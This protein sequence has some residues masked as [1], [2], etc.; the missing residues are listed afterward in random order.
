MNCTF[1]DNAAFYGAGLTVG[2][3]G[4]ATTTNCIFWGNSTD[5]IALD[6]LN[7]AGGTL[8]VNYCDIQGGEN[9]VNVIDPS[10]STFNWGIE[11]ID[12]D[13]IFENSGNGNYHL[14]NSSPCIGAAID[15]IMI[16]GTMCHCPLIDIEGLPR[17]YPV[18]T[19][20]DMGA[21]EYQFPV[22]VE[23]NETAQPTEFS[24]SQNYPNPF[25]PITTIQYQIP[26]RSN[27]SLKVYDIIGNEIAEL[28]NEEQEV[29]YYDAEFNAARLSSGVYFYRLQAVDFIQTRKMILLK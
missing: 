12:E 6:T 2:G 28:V 7:S 18:G 8:K 5:Q 25:N 15:S 11:N 27:V 1:T 4:T 23:E 21:Y 26:K 16:N 19:M 20:P 3:G 22:D 10:I 13:P 29:G 24:L 9:S 14:K 17:P